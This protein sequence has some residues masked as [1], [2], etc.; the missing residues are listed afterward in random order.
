MENL[1]GIKLENIYIKT[2]FCNDMLNSFFPSEEQV[3]ADSW[4]TCFWIVWIHLYTDFF[5][6][7]YVGNI[8][9]SLQQFGK[10]HRWTSQPRNRET[11]NKK[12]GILYTYKI[13]LSASLFYKLQP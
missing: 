9:G 7:K 5:F 4:T 1:T 6:N 13:C 2:N 10:T 11:I 3:Q 8:F 12:L